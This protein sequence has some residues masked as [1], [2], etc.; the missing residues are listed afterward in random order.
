MLDG[1]AVFYA[2]VCLV[3]IKFRA[4]YFRLSNGPSCIFCKA[5]NDAESVR[6]CARLLAA[7]YRVHHCAHCN[8]RR[9]FVG[10]TPA[11]STLKIFSERAVWRSDKIFVLSSICEVPR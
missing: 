1:Y 5:S 2:G 6:A 11:S 9:F 7:F 10:A 3:F 4:I 8:R